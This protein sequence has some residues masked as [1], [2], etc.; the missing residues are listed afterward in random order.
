MDVG[1]EPMIIKIKEALRS[2]HSCFKYEKQ[3]I[4]MAAVLNAYL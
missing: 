3:R 2:S 4:K 1:F